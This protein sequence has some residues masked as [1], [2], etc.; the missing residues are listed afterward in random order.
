GYTTDYD[1]V[2]E[3]QHN[4]D[5]ISVYKYMSELLKKQGDKVKA[6]EAIGIVGKSP[7][8]AG[9]PHLYFELWNKGVAINPQDYIVF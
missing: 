7:A 1:Y 2:I 9:F 6:G 5:Y 3:V 8:R 4:N